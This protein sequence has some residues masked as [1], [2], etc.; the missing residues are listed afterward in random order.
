M[1]IKIFGSGCSKCQR[2]AAN[3]Q[4]AA[5]SLGLDFTMTKVTDTGDIVDAGVLKTPALGIDDELKVMGRVPS[6]E[7]LERVLGEAGDA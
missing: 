7:E 4:A 2:L 5:E 6:T 1:E 3:A